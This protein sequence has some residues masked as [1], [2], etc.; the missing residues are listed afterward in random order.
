MKLITALLHHVRVTAVIDALNDAGYRNLN[1]QDVKGTLKPLGD[2]E[3]T[4]SSE[5]RLVISEVQLSLPCED[6]EVESITSIIRETGRIGT[7]VSGWVYVSAIEQ[8]WP[9]GGS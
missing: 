8:A 2:F 1:L 4:Y 3:L 6:G 9:I 7:D 5:A